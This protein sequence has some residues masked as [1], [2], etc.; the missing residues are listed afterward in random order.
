MLQKMVCLNI[1]LYEYS[2]ISFH[3]VTILKD[4]DSHRSRGVAFVL[5]LDRDG[6]QNCVQELDN[7]QVI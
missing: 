6:A 4:K 1:L 7:T 3:R 2:L 5:F